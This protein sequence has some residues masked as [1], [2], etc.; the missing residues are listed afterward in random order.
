M[1][2]LLFTRRQMV[3]VLVLLVVTTSVSGFAAITTKSIAKLPSAETVPV[4]NDV[5]QSQ[6]IM[7]SST[8]TMQD[9]EVDAPASLVFYDDVLDDEEPLGVVCARG[10]CVISYDDDDD[11]GMEMTT[12]TGNESQ[13]LVD[14]IVNSY[15]GPRILLA[16][17]SILYGTNFPLGAIMNDA[18]PPSA[19]TS[20]R[21]VLASAALGPFLF[22]LDKSL[23]WSSLLCGCFT[24]LGYVTQSLALVDTSPAKVAFLGAATVI[25]CPTL[26]GLI[27]K[28]PMGIKDAPQTWL[29]AILCLAGVGILELYDP[30]T[31]GFAD[32]TQQVGFGDVLSIL[33]AVG[34]G[35][36]FFLTERM[37]RKQPDQAL[38]I[39]AVQVSTT[40]L[41]CM[42]WCLADGW[43][44][45]GGAAASSYGLPGLLLDP[46]VRIAAGAVAWTGLITTAMNRFV[47]TTSL[48]KVP[49]AEASVILATEPL[50]AALFAAF[51]LSESFGANDYVG[52]FLIVL[53]CLAN[54]LKPTDFFKEEQD[55]LSI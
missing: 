35:T 52:G 3:I 25:V 32:V 55:D 47:E 18:L 54:T 27:N 17:A 24:A 30:A 8:T 15:L 41:I 38:P 45:D 23:G 21:M 16:F 44:F 34:F 46:T 36:S 49:S 14:R 50:W 5:V 2:N 28:K 48:G 11:D 51:I 7:P 6:S 42:V 20:A 13:S 26:E 22:K 43:M 40:A 4:E 33:Q 10:V 12:D 9:E 1:K 29:A 39:T 37:M 19:A 31:G 53:A